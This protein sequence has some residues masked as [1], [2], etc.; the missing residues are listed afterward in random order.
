LPEV[1]EVDVIRHFTKLSMR[2]IGVD[3]A[4]YPLGS[5][6]MK[7]NPKVNEDLA[8]LPGFAS[9]HPLQPADDA[10]G[11][12]RLMYELEQFLVEI[13]GMDAASLQPAAGAQGEMTGLM[14]IR[15]F[16]VANGDLSRKKILVPDSSHG[17]N[18]ASAALTGFEVVEVK[19]NDRGGV[20]LEDLKRLTDETVAGLML[21]NPNTLGLFDENVEEIVEIVHNAGGLAYYDGANMNA[22]LGIC[23]PGDMGFDVMHFNLHKT[24]STPHGGGG[25][26]SGPVAVKKHLSRFLPKPMI[27]KGNDGRYY[28]DD[29]CPDSIGKVRSFYGNVGVCIKAYC[30]IRQMGADG[31]AEVSKNAVLNANYLLSRLKGTYDLPYDRPCMHEFVLSA[32]NLKGSGVKARDIAK[33]LLDYGVHPP[34]VYFPLIVHEAL[35]VEP[36]ETESIET[37]DAFA[38]AMIAIARECETDK[39]KVLGAPHETV[40]GR[41]DEVLAARKPDLRWKPH[42]CATAD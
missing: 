15:A 21:T 33:R 26:G 12:L 18:P 10:Q 41:L 32:A 25:P 34:T 2:S 8:S 23:R 30:Y 31:L 39:E 3:T 24:F 40:V 13:G 4:F 5:C 22:I 37:L 14:L 16:H 29:D 38:D 28:L 20:D 7:Y 36:T 35:M 6:T 27:R 19:S 9:V 17:T 1:S 11:T 42:A